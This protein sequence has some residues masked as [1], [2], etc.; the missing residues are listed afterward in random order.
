MKY[1]IERLESIGGKR[2]NSQDKDRIY[3][4]PQ[5]IKKLNSEFED[6]GFD[7]ILKECKFFYDINN[8]VTDSTSYTVDSMDDKRLRIES[9]IRAKVMDIK[10]RS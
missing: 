7:K 5:V 6:K 2:W 10:R 3:F 9:Y 4:N 1:L 8:N